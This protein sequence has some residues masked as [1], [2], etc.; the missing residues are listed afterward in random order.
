MP[1]GDVLLFRLVVDGH[2]GGLVNLCGL[3]DQHLRRTDNKRDEK[4]SLHVSET[5]YL[6]AGCVLK[7]PACL[8]VFVQETA[9]DWWCAA[10]PPR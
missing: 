8:C 1:N 6:R 4:T 5:L 7:S 9:G 10:W 2:V 3:Q